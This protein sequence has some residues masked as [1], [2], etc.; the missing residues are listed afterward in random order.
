M[1]VTYPFS[2][3]EKG[4]R[5]SK[6]TKDEEVE[7]W[8]NIL[9]TINSLVSRCNT[10]NSTSISNITIVHQDSKPGPLTYLE[11]DSNIAA[12]E[13]KLNQIIVASNAQGLNATNL[14]NL[15][16]A[17]E[18]EAPLLIWQRDTNFK[19]IKTAINTINILYSWAEA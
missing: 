11:Y 5:T 16:Q 7:I 9:D 19:T 14:V 1:A 15:I 17:S 12:I 10:L 13:A 8:Q 18:N 2:F 4:G 3:P 6:I